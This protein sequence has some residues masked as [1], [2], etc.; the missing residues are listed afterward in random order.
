MG[1]HPTPS[2]PPRPVCRFTSGKPGAG[3]DRAHWG[4]CLQEACQAPTGRAREKQLH[5][6]SS[7]C[8]GLSPY[9]LCPR[10]PSPSTLRGALPHTQHL[11]S[12][13]PTPP[14]SICWPLYSPGPVRGDLSLSLLQSRA[15]RGRAGLQCPR[16]GHQGGHHA[17]WVPLWP[18]TCPQNPSLAPLGPRGLGPGLGPHKGHRAPAGVG[19]SFEGLEG[20]R[21][22]PG[23]WT[24]WGGWCQAPAWLGGPMRAAPTLSREHPHVMVLGSGAHSPS[25]GRG[26]SREPASRLTVSVFLRLCRLSLPPEPQF[27]AS[28]SSRPAEPRTS[29]SL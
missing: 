12:R 6:A 2:C 15:Q 27:S 17:L 5:A 11:P 1:P 23:P 8:P 16:E 21:K 3:L 28:T 25:Q 19:V 22:P 26:S 4:W 10:S 24:S 14:W 29:A 20:T 7:P 9:V 13:V 18:Q